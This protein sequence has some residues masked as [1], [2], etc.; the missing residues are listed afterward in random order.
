MPKKITDIPINTHG[1][2]PSARCAEAPS[3]DEQP[4]AGPTL[5]QQAE[6]RSRDNA[7]C[8]ADPALTMSPEE[9][10][11]MTHE[12]QVHQIELEMQNEELRTAHEQLDSALARYR[13]LFDHAPAGYVMV[14]QAGL[15]QEVN[16]AAANLLGVPRNLLAGQPLASFIH[17]DDQDIYYLHRNQLLDGKAPVT[18]KLRMV[19]H[20]GAVFWAQVDSTITRDSNAQPACRIILSDI[21]A[22]QRAAAL[23][24]YQADLLDKVSDAVIATDEKFHITSWNA[25]AEKI[26]GWSAGEVIGKDL[27]ELL[28]AEFIGIDKPQFEEQLMTLG[29]VSA[30]VIHKDRHGHLRYMH[31]N[32][33]LLKNDHGGVTGTLGVLRDI[34]E[35][36]QAEEVL[37]ESVLRFRMALRNSPVS[38]AF[39]DRNLVYQWAYNQQTQLLDEVIGKT[40]ADLYSAGDLALL[41]AAKLRVLE[42]GTE[43]SQRLWLTRDGRRLFLSFYLEPVRDAAGQITGIGIT[44]VNLTEQ[45]QA[46]EE[47]RAAHKA[48][49]NIMQDAIAARQQAEQASAALRES[50]A[51]QRARRR[52]LETL[53]DAIPSAVFIAHDAAC[54]RITGNPAALDLLRMPTGSNFSK[55]ADD[56]IPAYEVWSDGRL[57]EAHELPMQRA[58]ATGEAVHGEESEI[59]FPDGTKRQIIGSALPLFDDSGAVRGCIGAFMDLTAYK[60]GQEE[61]R[62]LNR[63]LLALN[64]SNRA[65]L[66][67]QSETELLEDVCRIITATCGHA[68]VWIGFAENDR[69]KT[70]RPVACAGFDEGYLDTLHISWDDT[71]RGRGPTGTAIR[72]GQPNQCT[73][74]LTAP[75]FIPWRDEALK[76]GFASSLALPLME[77]GKAFGAVTIYSRQAAGFSSDEKNLLGD[78][79]G[80]LALGITTLRLREA[81]R[82]AEV[83]L[84]ESEA[85]FRSTFHNAA[86]PMAVK[87][88]D[89]RILEVNQAYCEMLGYSEEELLAFTLEDL[90]HPDDRHAIAHEALRELMERGLSAFRS[91]KRYL[92]KRGHPVWCDTS[93]SLVRNPDGSVAYMIAQAHD[94]TARKQAEAEIRLLN[95]Q[96]ET[97]VSERTAE[98]YETVSVLETEIL[99]RHRLEREILEISEREQSRLGQDLHDGLGQ[100]L[101]GIAMLSDVLAKQLQAQSHP[102]SMVADKI[103]T[104]VRQSIDSTRRLAKGHYPIE[105]DRYGLLLALKDLADQT[106][107]RTGIHCE[108]RQ[109]GPEPSLEKSAEIHIYRIVQE[110]IGNAVKHGH[111]RNIIIESLAADSSH[112]FTITDDGSGGAPHAGSVGMGIHLMDYRARLIGATI[113]R[114]QPEQGGYRVTCSLAISKTPQEP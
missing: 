14:N 105:L 24:H 27:V 26:Y 69:A 28:H 6:D 23:L 42:S 70:V 107:H 30:E 99:N 53:M 13:D 92:H 16:F 73:H 61:L 62:R 85:R 43:E 37:R 57:L 89:G 45:Q 12:L 1:G 112:T 20:D 79:V 81:Q 19:R 83:A 11:R 40:D 106:R 75:R 18:C 58:A 32:V 59:V 104:H 82:Q 51:T 9:S 100:E 76:R 31:A 29:R 71:E 54:Q 94:I 55:S 91:E 66:Q 80:D 111:P 35:R 65:Q 63:T 77:N 2:L 108:L 98:L 15:L 90:V 25:A 74:I 67:A 44:T 39:Q 101:S 46:E 113:T 68:M 97:R 33:A 78:L 103:A 72:T 87:H 50:E 109:C 41:H 110:C 88:T 64:D 34:T 84:L 4:G 17:T 48:A 47:L 60:Q 7:P 52:E 36:H 22:Q 102:S 93:V 96:L 3:G 10:G 5:R 114:D 21:T 56:P 49:L 95:R 8:P 38:V 86:T